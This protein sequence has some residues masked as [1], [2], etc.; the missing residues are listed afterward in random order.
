MSTLMMEAAGSSKGLYLSTRQHR[1]VAYEVAILAQFEYDNDN[2][3]P[4][5]E[6]RRLDLLTRPFHWGLLRFYQYLDKP[7]GRGFDFR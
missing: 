5:S 7:E 1:V 6:E 3:Y 2:R 4:Y